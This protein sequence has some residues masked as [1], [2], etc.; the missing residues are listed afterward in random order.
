MPSQR[1][2]AKLRPLLWPVS[3]LYW[4]VAWCRNF[5]Y[6]TGFFITRRVSVPVVSIGNLSVGGTGKTPATIFV[7]QHLINL[8]Y[9]VGIVSRG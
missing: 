6:N 9:K 1:T 7:A 4:G 3:L 2:W 5:F 8:G